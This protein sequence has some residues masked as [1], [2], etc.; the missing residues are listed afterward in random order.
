[1]VST[2]EDDRADLV[3]GTFTITIFDAGVACGSTYN[4]E[5]DRE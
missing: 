5:A 4:F 1:M 2:Q 3:T